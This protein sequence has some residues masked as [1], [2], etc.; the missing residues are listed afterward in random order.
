MRRFVAFACAAVAAVAFAPAA[1]RQA[2][3]QFDGLAWM[4]GCWRSER[5]G[6]VSEEQWMAPAGGAMFGTSRTVRGGR[7]MEFEFLEI[8]AREDGVDY[9][10][11]PSGQATT[12]FRLTAPA[13]DGKDAV[14]E[15]PEHDFP[16]RVVY[17]H[18]PDG[19]MHARIEGER[20]GQLRVIDFSKARTACPQ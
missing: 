5:G 18:E 3:S 8:R 7:L 20:N 14:F 6:V 13:T 19:S 10:A 15:N 12:A 4:A 2:G 17:R 1:G 16:R 9:V 11:H